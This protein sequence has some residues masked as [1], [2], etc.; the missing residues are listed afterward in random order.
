MNIPSHPLRQCQRCKPR[1]MSRRLLEWL[2]E[3]RR[4]VVLV[5]SRRHSYEHHSENYIWET[6]CSAV[7]QNEIAD[8]GVLDVPAAA[9]CFWA[10]ED[11]TSDGQQ[12]ARTRR[13]P[14][15]AV[16]PTLA[17]GRNSTHRLFLPQRARTTICS[18][19]VCLPEEGDQ[20][21]RCRTLLIDYA[22]SSFRSRVSI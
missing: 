7:L 15:V 20:G 21:Y 13:D 3:R 2:Y 19:S 22:R 17:D 12:G 18:R 4:Q 5:E 9:R 1:I 16:I 11:G 6:K 8:T 14:T 10:K